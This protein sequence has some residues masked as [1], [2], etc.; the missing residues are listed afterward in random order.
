VF[1]GH[2]A[3]AFAAKR[4]APR[5][6]LPVLVG[7]AQFADLLWPFLL[8]AG[9]EQV[10]IAPGDTAFTPLE[11]V[12]YPYS[13]SL[14][15]LVVWGVAFGLI[16]RAPSPSDRSR[17]FW[18]LAL[19][20]VSH[21]VLDFVTHRPD[22][23]L[24][25]GS[26][27]FGLGLWNHPAATIAIEGALFVAGLAVYISATRPRDRTGRWALVGFVALL[28]AAYAANILGGPPPSISALAIGAIIGAVIL[29]VFSWWVDAHREAREELRY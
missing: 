26:A 29:L 28:I 5:T 12:S 23:P 8:L 16:A 24:Y 4:A 17:R 25:P 2:F 10:R 13:H 1:I 19:L 27:K 11:F 18:V 7:A 21:W 3:L 20:V 14:A 9:V 22:M 6:S 15:M